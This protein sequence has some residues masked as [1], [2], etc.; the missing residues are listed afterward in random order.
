MNRLKKYGFKDENGHP[1]ENCSDYLTIFDE[2]KAS[3]G[4]VESDLLEVLKLAE[5]YVEGTIGW[6]GEREITLSSIRA[7]I[8]K[9]EGREGKE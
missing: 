7:A 4:S 6:N 9:A 2:H 3:L 1:L 5:K 8:A